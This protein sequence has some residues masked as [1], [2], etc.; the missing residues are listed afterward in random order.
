MSE[1]PALLTRWAWFVTAIQRREC[2]HEQCADDVSQPKNLVTING[3]TT[4]TF[5][6]IRKGLDNA[7]FRDV[8]LLQDGERMNGVI[9]AFKL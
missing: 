9:E 3:G 6:E 4:H 2:Y 8:R 1:S 7:G 5:Q